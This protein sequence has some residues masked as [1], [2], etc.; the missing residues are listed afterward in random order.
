MATPQQ[1]AI[2]Q[3]YTALFNRAPDAAGLAFWDQAMSNGASIDTIAQSFLTA[4]EA[5]AIYPGTAPTTLFV[6]RFYTTVFGRE[7]DP[8]GLAFWSAALDA[9]GGAGNAA[10]RAALVTQLV[11]IV[12]TPLDTKPAGISDDAYAQTVA[13]RISPPS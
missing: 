2:T 8:E 5:L 4:P 13:D 7:P 11:D 12:S 6:A 3:L 10:A 1:I 9:Q